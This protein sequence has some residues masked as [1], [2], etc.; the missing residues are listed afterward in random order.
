MDTHKHTEKFWKY[1]GDRNPVKDC[2]NCEPGA[3]E[4]LVLKLME[5][6]I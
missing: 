2:N 3:V 1:L 4:I 6:Y 5:L